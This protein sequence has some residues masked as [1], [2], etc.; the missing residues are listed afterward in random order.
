MFS[1]YFLIVDSLEEFFYYTR[2]VVYDK[3]SPDTQTLPVHLCLI[4]FCFLKKFSIL[5]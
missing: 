1:S 5:C 4:L 3:N 2:L